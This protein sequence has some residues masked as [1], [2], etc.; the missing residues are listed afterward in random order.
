MRR[1]GLHDTSL[2]VCSFVCLLVSVMSVLFCLFDAEFVCLCV[3]FVCVFV[4]VVLFVCLFVCV[5][6]RL[7]E[8]GRAHIV[9]MNAVEIGGNAWVG[10]C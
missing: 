7:L 8:W 4:L 10:R 5:V 1:G 2:F 9:R 3:S 6:V